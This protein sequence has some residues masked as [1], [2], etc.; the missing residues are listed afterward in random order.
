MK[1]HFYYNKS[2][3]SRGIHL[4]SVTGE[5]S[6]DAFPAATFGRRCDHETAFVSLQILHRGS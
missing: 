2:G 4:S 5:A 3:H 1:Y 6:P